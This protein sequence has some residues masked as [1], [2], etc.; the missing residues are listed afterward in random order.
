MRFLHSLLP[1]L[2]LATSGVSAAS[3]WGFTDATVTRLS[4]AESDVK[5]S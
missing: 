5:Q 1:V 3:S 2:A 4:K